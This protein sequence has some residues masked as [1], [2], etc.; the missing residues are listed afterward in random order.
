VDVRSLIGPFNRPI[1]P[2]DILRDERPIPSPDLKK[3]RTARR[4][5]EKVRVKINGVEQGMFIQSRD[6]SYPVLLF[7]HGGPGM[8]EYFLTKRYPTGLE[9][10]FTV[11]WWEQRGSG[12]SFNR[13]VRPE[14]MTVEQ[15]I[16]D[17]L[18][19]TDYLRERYGKD[20]IYLMAHSGGSFYGIQ[21]AAR[22]PEL[23][24][25]YIGVAQMSFQLRS[26][27]EAYEYMLKRYRERGD[28]RM[29]RRLEKGSPSITAPLPSSYDSIRDK[30][31]HRLGIGTTRDM[32]SVITGVFIPS[33]LSRDYTL[34]EKIGI[35]R[36]KF[37]SMRL[38]RDTVFATDL[39]KIVMELTIPAYFFSG[40]HDLTVSYAGAR[41]YFEELR[42]P[43]KGF[44]A[45]EMSAHSPMFEEPEKFRTILKEDVLARKNDLADAR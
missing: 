2:G 36:G 22:S 20:K 37:F 40:K 43:L 15:F 30:A 41:S 32:R 24:H 33:W 10:L 14:T 1:H 4:I 23:F 29:V 25:A 39:T 12:L 11:V 13:D 34:R 6:E 3:D 19:V 31:M 5:A 7:L 26:E 42:A 35:W 44:Y 27:K 8:P 16:S 28:A 45:F 9:E 21:A 38:L 17:T 18:A